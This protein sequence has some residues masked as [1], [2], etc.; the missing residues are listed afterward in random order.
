MAIDGF[1]DRGGVMEERIDRRMGKRVAED[2]EDSFAA[3]HAG[4]PVMA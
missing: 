2:F 4:E 3:A 1:G